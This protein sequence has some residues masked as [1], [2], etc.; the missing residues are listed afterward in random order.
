M[1]CVFHKL[2]GCTCVKCGREFHAYK[3]PNRKTCVCSRCYK[4]NP[5]PAAHVLP[6]APTVFLDQPARTRGSVCHCTRCNETV[7]DW[8][9]CTCRKCGESRGGV[10][11]SGHAWD[12]CVCTKCGRKRPV[13]HDSHAWDG[14]VC[15]KCGET[16]PIEVEGHA[17]QG[18]VCQRCGAKRDDQHAWDGCKCKA[19]GARRDSGHA[20]DL[21]RCTLCGA[22]KPEDSPEHDWNVCV[23][24]HCDLKKSDH[25]A[26]DLEEIAAI[27]FYWYR[28][29]RCG[30]S[31]NAW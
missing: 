25:A 14:C 5:N 24:R 13:E 16:K 7:H 1:T 9:G 8:D 12:G 21:C 29:R 30:W 19:C 15:T 6:S 17:W 22:A 4:I 11:E 23:C 10:D 27:D 18:C 28:C 2:K 3:T 26:H 20:W 31:Y